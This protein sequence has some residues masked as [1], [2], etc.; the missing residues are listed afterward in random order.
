M[1]VRHAMCVCD[2]CVVILSQKLITK[3]REDHCMCKI[4]VRRGSHRHAP[5]AGFREQLYML[6][7]STV[8]HIICVCVCMR[9]CTSVCARA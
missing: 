4:S 5:S 3:Y 2:V 8:K 7:N 1:K 9:V 6:T